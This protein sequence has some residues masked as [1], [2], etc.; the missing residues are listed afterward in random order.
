MRRTLMIKLRR[1]DEPHKMQK[2]FHIDLGCVLFF[3]LERLNT[4]F[5]IQRCAM[6]SIVMEANIDA[7]LNLYALKEIEH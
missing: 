3:P 7:T 5:A 6:H 2:L 1:F 4:T